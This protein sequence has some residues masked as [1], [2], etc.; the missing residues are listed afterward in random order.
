MHRER[1]ANVHIFVHSRTRLAADLTRVASARGVGMKLSTFEC[2]AKERHDRVV[3]GSVDESLR[4]LARCRPRL[5]RECAARELGTR[6]RPEG[7]QIHWRD[8]FRASVRASFP[9]DLRDEE[10][11]RITKSARYRRNSVISVNNTYEY[12]IIDLLL[13]SYYIAYCDSH[14]IPFAILYFYKCSTCTESNRC[15]TI[16]PSCLHVKLAA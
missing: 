10:T 9:I 2:L 7:R 15:S 6:T 12:F 11:R 1:F 8:M 14:V 13:I 16:T 5:L 3:S 4:Q